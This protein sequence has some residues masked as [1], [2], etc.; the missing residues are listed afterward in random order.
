MVGED[1]TEAIK[2]FFQNKK[3]LKQINA[4]TIVLLPKKENPNYIKD[5]CPLACCSVPYKI[6]SKIIAARLGKV[7]PDIISEV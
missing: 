7:L 4:T 6:I 2:E 1:V 3:I 5:Y